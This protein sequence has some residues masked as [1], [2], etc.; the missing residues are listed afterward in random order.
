MMVSNKMLVQISP[1]ILLVSDEFVA[2]HVT[3]TDMIK[4][5]L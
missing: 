1:R 2:F 3:S 4:I 5:L